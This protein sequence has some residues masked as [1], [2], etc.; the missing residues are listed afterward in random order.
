MP[1]ARALRQADDTGVSAGDVLPTFGCPPWTKWLDA[2]TSKPG[3]RNGRLYAIVHPCS[4]RPCRRNF[5][6]RDA[7]RLTDI[8]GLKKRS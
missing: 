3:A 6:S 2:A 5:R 1:I 7:S 8:V 4:G